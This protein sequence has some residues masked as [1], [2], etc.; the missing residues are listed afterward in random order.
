MADKKKKK[1]GNKELG[2]KE[3]KKGKK[4]LN[5][6]VEALQSYRLDDQVLSLLEPQDASYVQSA[7]SHIRSSDT[8]SDPLQASKDLQ[9]LESYV[10]EALK[11]TSRD[12]R[13]KAIN[14]VN[15]MDA[16]GYD[17]AGSLLKRLYP[18]P[19]AVFAFVGD[20]YW[21]AVKS[22]REVR[23][24]TEIDGFDFYT[25]SATTRRK[26]KLAYKVL[27]ELNL[28]KLRTELIDHLNLFGNA[29]LK[30]KRNIL[31]G[32]LE[33]EV[34]LPERMLPLWDRNN[35]KIIGWQY[36]VNQ[37]RVIYGVDELVHLKTYSC[38]SQQ[39]GA[40]G[41]G[42]VI[43][44]IEAAMFASLFNNTV[45]Q[46]GG[47]VGN[48]ISLKGMEGNSLINENNYSLLADAVQARFQKQHGGVQGAG[49]TIIS[50]FVDKVFKLMN[51]GEMDGTHQNM[52]AA[53]DRKVALLLG[54]APE[55][56]GIPITSQYQDKGL[57][58][59]RVTEAF[60]NNAYYLASI[61]DDF[62]TEVV[63]ASTGAH[64]IIIRP[65]SAHKANALAA[66]Q[67]GDLM[68]KFGGMTYDEY[69]IDVLKREP[70]GGELGN[71]IM[72]TMTLKEGDTRVIETAPPSPNVNVQFGGKAIIK[73]AARHV[74]YY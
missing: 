14:I 32:I 62:L 7:L 25:L 60:D 52:T 50:P 9:G 58:S 65:G 18:N 3:V 15:G 41:L 44:D 26:I 61:V 22:R 48:I 10:G 72:S 35:D 68:A 36:L 69:R 55:R 28:I 73:H 59:D 71:R 1:G 46:K 33:Y 29:W 31:G 19:F 51:V 17:P 57:T 6:A 21:A 74:R 56:I 49:Q 23:V 70:W 13:L 63:R 66:A 12:N 16:V 64:D 5:E 47:M 27:E 4:R 11:R 43:V 24:E 45:F 38:R 8:L 37:Q 67:Y 20:N 34:L 54:C 40:P 39:L 2:K 53:T 30:P 42:S